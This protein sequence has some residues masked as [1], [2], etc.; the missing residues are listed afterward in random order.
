MKRFPSEANPCGVEHFSAPPLLSFPNKSP[1][2]VSAC[3]DS[4][5]NQTLHAIRCTLNLQLGSNKLS[6]IDCVTGTAR[7]I[8]TYLV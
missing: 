6:H 8:L 4:V 1:G 3:Q 2:L 7:G 5:M